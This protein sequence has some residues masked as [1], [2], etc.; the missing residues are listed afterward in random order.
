MKNSKLLET[1]IEELKE[2]QKNYYNEKKAIYKELRDLA[3]WV[4]KTTEEVLEKHRVYNGSREQ[5]IASYVKAVEELETLGIKYDKEH[6]VRTA[7]NGTSYTIDYKGMT[8]SSVETFVTRTGRTKRTYNIASNYFLK[9]ETETLYDIF[10]SGKDTDKLA[11]KE[12]DNYVASLIKKVESRYGEIKDVTD[13]KYSNVARVIFNC[14]N[15]SCYLEMIT[16]G[17]YNIQR[18]HNRLLIKDVK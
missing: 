5:W 18:L 16:A 6:F 17:G 10:E 9:K 7:K 11:E 4:Y 15:G 13:Y 2:E 3:R 12:I 1:W 8:L 14:E